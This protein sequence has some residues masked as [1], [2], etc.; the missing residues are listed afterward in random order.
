[1]SEANWS[2]RALDSEFLPD[3][4]FRLAGLTEANG[5]APRR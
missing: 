3:T 4:A 1:V 2:W 5:R